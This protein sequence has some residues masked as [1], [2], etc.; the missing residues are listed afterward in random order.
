[1]ARRQLRV[2]RD[3]D[4]DSGW[5]AAEGVVVVASRKPN[6]TDSIKGWL[7][8][9]IERWTQRRAAQENGAPSADFC[10]APE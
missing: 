8:E 1:M 9:D 5:Q 6:V 7:R 2:R 3:H 4:L 10:T